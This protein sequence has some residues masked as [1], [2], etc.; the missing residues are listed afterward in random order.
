MKALQNYNY[1]D[2]S[3][4]TSILISP[5]IY[6]PKYTPVGEGGHDELKAK[7]MS[8]RREMRSC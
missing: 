7:P 5:T 1:K 4:L 3:I 6:N 8:R 2:T